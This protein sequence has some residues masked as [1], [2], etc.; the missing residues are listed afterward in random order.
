VSG[1]R[2]RFAHKNRTVGDRCRRDRCGIQS[3]PSGELPC[4]CVHAAP[5]KGPE[6]TA[7]GPTFQNDIRPIFERNCLRC[8]NAKVKKGGLDLSTSERVLAGG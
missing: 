4:T 6:A 2:F 7:K 5:S 8:H 1:I 3:G